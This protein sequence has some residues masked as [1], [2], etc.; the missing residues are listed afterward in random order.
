MKVFESMKIVL[1][2]IEIFLETQFDA[3]E[4]QNAK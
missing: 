4:F 1:N 3:S 2:S